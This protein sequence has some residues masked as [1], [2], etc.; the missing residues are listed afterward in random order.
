MTSEQVLKM[1]F[2][3]FLDITCKWYR[4]LRLIFSIFSFSKGYFSKALFMASFKFEEPSLETETLKGLFSLLI[5]NEKR[6]GLPFS[7]NFDFLKYFLG[8][9]FLR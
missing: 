1:F 7:L 9:S 6:I 8:T 5:L 3:P 2:H 4:L